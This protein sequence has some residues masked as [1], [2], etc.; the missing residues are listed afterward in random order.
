VRGGGK[1]IPTLNFEINNLSGKGGQ[2][3][4]SEEEKAWSST[5]VVPDTGGGKISPK[6]GKNL[7][8]RFSRGARVT[9]RGKGGEKGYREWG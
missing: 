1:Q 5:H 8:V 9:S 4:G 7:I 2:C 6:G 3:P